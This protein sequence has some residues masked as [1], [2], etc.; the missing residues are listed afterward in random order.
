[1]PTLIRFFNAKGEVTETKEWSSSGCYWFDYGAW[2][3]KITDKSYYAWGY[4]LSWC[5]ARRSLR[6]ATKRLKKEFEELMK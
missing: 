6:T 5:G 2:S 4:G 3:D 1:M